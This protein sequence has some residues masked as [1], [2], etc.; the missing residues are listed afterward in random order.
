MPNKSVDELGEFLLKVNDLINFGDHGDGEKFSPTELLI[1]L[2]SV[3]KW[4]ARGCCCVTCTFLVRTNRLMDYST[5]TVRND[6][7]TRAWYNASVNGETFSSS[8]GELLLSHSRNFEQKSKEQRH[9]PGAHSSTN[10][11]EP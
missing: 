9:E 1:K 7:K 11:G 2:Q 8:D 6:E 3:E 10:H 4:V 5:S